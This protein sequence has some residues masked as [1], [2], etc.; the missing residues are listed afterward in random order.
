MSDLELERAELFAEFLG[1]RG[2]P[3]GLEGFRKAFAKG[4]QGFAC[5]LCFEVWAEHSCGVTEDEWREGKINRLGEW[6]IVLDAGIRDLQEAC[7][8]PWF[9]DWG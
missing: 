2:L 6:P 3:R 9:E 5:V 7:L 1:H 4:L 8:W